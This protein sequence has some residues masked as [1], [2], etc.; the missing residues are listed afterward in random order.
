LGKI[1]RRLCFYQMD[2]CYKL[3]F[4]VYHAGFSR[5]SRLAIG[6]ITVEIISCSAVLPTGSM[7]RPLIPTYRFL[8]FRCR[9]VAASLDGRGVVAGCHSR[10]CSTKYGTSPSALYFKWFMQNIFNSHVN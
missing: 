3:Q 10:F 2:C 1:H 9:F 7:G 5:F 6:L 8:F 4:W